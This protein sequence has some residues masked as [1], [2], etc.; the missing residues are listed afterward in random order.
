MSADDG[1]TTVSLD[2]ATGERFQLLRKELG[3]TAFGINLLRFEP[4]QRTRIHRH[5]RQEEVYL[6]LEGELTLLTDAGER[7]L[8]RL[9]IARVPAEVRRQL[10]NQGADPLRVL[11][12]GGAGRHQGRDGIAYAQWSDGPD[13]GREPRDVPL[14]PDL[15]VPAAR[16][17]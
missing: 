1:V 14:P 8:R 12:M 2:L 17:E 5:E 4:G 6:V 15:Q 11:A 3:V 7:T 10:V 9:D 16:T 13:D